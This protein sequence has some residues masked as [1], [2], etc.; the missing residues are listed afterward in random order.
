MIDDLKPIITE[1]KQKHSGQ[2]AAIL[3]GGPS[4]IEQIKYFPGNTILFSINHHAAM[5]CQ[6]DY[7]IFYDFRGYD[8]V[9]Q[10]PG[11][12]LTQINKD[13]DYLFAGEIPFMGI[14]ACSA[15]MIALYMGFDEILLAG[16][17]CYLSTDLYW[18][19]AS[20]PPEHMPGS[21]S[22]LKDKQ[23]HIQHWANLS[24]S[25]NKNDF[26][27]IFTMNGQLSQYFNEYTTVFPR[28]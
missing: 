8:L 2:T 28:K 24:K 27:K 19:T 16:M 3:G 6:C 26:E 21:A 15:V 1:L 11:I 20:L 18:H 14:S 9:K 4:L 12:K 10:Y 13:T 25:L 23:E 5:H 22:S 17:D 7:I